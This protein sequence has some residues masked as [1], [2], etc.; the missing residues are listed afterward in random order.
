MFVKQG[1]KM[2]VNSDPISKYSG[3]AIPWNTVHMKETVIT[4]GANKHSFISL[5]QEKKSKH[6][7]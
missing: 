6:V 7:F 1:F 3:A 4:G 2:W 5:H